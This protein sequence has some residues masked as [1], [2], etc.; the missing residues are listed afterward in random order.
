MQ[1]LRELVENISSWTPRLKSQKLLG[2]RDFECIACRLYKTL[3]CSCDLTV[4]KYGLRMTLNGKTTSFKLA[5]SGCGKAFG[6]GN[7]AKYYLF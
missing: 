4:G 1:D 6:L 5:P 7:F 2:W 3:D